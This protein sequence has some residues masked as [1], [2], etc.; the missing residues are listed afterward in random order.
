MFHFCFVSLPPLPSLYYCTAHWQPP[1]Q[2]F[3]KQAHVSLVLFSYQSMASCRRTAF[4]LTVIVP[5]KRP[6]LC[7]QPFISIGSSKSKLNS[8]SSVEASLSSRSKPGN[9]NDTTPKGSSA[10]IPSESFNSMI[11]E[12]WSSSCCVVICGCNMG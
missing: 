5:F 6:V 7:V 3:D 11:N 9:R 8:F 2:A 4:Q 10:L 1:W 12:H